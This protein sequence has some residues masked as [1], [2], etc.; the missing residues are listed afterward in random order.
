MQLSTS[1]VDDEGGCNENGDRDYYRRIT[2]T[3]LQQTRPRECALN[4]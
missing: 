1:H 4:G 3:S 2:G